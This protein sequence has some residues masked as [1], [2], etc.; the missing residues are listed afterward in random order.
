LYAQKEPWTSNKEKLSWKIARLGIIDKFIDK[1][2]SHVLF[3]TM[4]NGTS[5][6]PS[7]MMFKA[8][9]FCDKSND[10]T[11]ERKQQVPLLASH[12]H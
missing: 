5:D 2:L 6:A 12:P 11:I 4:F 8:P 1:L 7:M 3:I 10:K 9:Y